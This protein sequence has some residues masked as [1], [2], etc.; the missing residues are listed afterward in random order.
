MPR[1]LV[2]FLI[3]LAVQG[4]F[5]IP[6]WAEAPD[7]ESSVFLESNRFLEEAPA[8]NGLQIPLVILDGAGWRPSEVW[9]IWR[10][11]TAIFRRECRFRLSAHKLRLI[12]VKPSW[13]SL[14]EREQAE[15]LQMLDYDTRPV[16]F[17]IGSA[18]GDF[19]AFAYLEGTVSP[20][21]GTAWLTREIPRRCRARQL[22]HEI[23]HVLLQVGNHSTD[24]DNLMYRDCRRSNLGN[25]AINTDLNESQ[26]RTLWRR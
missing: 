2:E 8:D 22:A 26:C 17:F 13:Q 19:G 3:L 15:L 5:G 23:G 12:G 16:V 7:R 24:P 6:V 21:Q 4:W 10:E 9:N 25:F 14:D 20:S 1:P 18:E 11:A